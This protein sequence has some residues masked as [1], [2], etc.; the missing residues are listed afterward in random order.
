MLDG[1]VDELLVKDVDHL[2]FVKVDEHSSAC[3]ARNVS[4]RIGLQRVLD[5]CNS[6]QPTRHVSK[7][8]NKKKKKRPLNEGHFEVEAGFGDSFEHRSSKPVDTQVTLRDFVV[9][10]HDTETGDGCENSDDNPDGA[11]GRENVDTVNKH[12]RNNK[13][14]KQKKQKAG[15]EKRNGGR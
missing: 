5:M 15:L 8:H 11:H 6:V 10:V 14:M 2:D 13:R 1:L 4:H 12:K 3:S 7:T 9:R